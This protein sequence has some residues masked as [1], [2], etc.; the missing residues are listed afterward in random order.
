[1]LNGGQPASQTKPT[2]P[3]SASRSTS[4]TDS[5]SGGIDR[6]RWNVVTHG[7]GPTVAARNGLVELNI[8]A[9]AAA[10]AGEPI[11]AGLELNGCVATGNYVASVEY[12]I[13]DWPKLH[14]VEIAFGELAA[15]AALITRDQYADGDSVHGRGPLV[16][17]RWA[18]SS[19]TGSLRLTRK[20]GTVTVADLREDGLWHE[21]DDVR[22]PSDGEA[23][24]RVGLMSDAAQF[25]GRRVRIVVDNFQLTAAQV[26]C[27]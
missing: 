5:F 27:K 4:F 2:P 9:E 6:T 10:G 15:D 16:D 26:V 8:P 1:M 19:P 7:R 24:F 20:D 3:A 14:G 25:A 17:V 12:Q 13:L 18:V 22:W 23:R 11:S 21:F